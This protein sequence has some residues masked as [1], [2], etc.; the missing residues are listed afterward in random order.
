MRD[1]PSRVPR[2]IVLG[3]EGAGIVVQVGK[4]VRKV[5]PGD[6][7]VMTFD[8]CGLCSSCR[9]GDVAYC[10][11]LGQFNFSGSRP[12]G[13]TALSTESTPVHSHFFGQSSFATHS[14]CHERT[15]VKVP[16]DIPLDILGP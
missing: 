16:G 14:I 6:H 13:S 1:S 15:V 2:P 7:V 9:G 10:E 12:D 3:H 4:S 5:V 11:N 8:T